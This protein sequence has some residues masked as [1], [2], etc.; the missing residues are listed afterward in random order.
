MRLS[1][2]FPTL[3]ETTCECCGQSEVDEVALHLIEAAVVSFRDSLLEKLQRD[4][5]AWAE[6]ERLTAEAL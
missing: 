4:E 6:A 1:E 5:A 2:L 3:T